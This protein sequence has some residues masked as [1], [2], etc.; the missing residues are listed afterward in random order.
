MRDELTHDTTWSW[1]F[2]GTWGGDAAGIA[3]AAAGGG[4]L[5][6]A[7]FWGLWWTV[8]ALP[9]SQRPALLVLGSYLVRFAAAGLGFYLTARLGDGRHLIAAL[10]GF[11]VARAALTRR[12]RRGVATSANP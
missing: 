7:F 3:L 2:A 11:L 5:G 1:L 8:Q 9:R 12:A 10:G 6:A 4:L